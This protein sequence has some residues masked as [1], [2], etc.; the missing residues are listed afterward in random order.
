MSPAGVSPPVR[1]LALPLLLLVTLV[2]CDQATKEL[3]VS[4]LRQAPDV[5]LVAGVLDLSYTENRDVGFSLL[6]F[7]ESDAVR[8]GVIVALASGVLLVV[9]VFLVRR[10]RKLN[11][12]TGAALGLLAAG[13]VGN[14][15]DRVVRGHV[16]DFVHLHGWPVFNVADI[17]I[18]VGA[19]SLVLATRKRERDPPPA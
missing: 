7:I 12:L 4:H 8:R 6:R 14:L 15:L 1:R 13:A 19:V 9:G 18:T 5:P 3:A 11:A 17:C 16:I 10:R 2:G